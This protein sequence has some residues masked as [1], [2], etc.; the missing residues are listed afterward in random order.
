MCIFQL[1][2]VFQRIHI[3]IQTDV[4]VQ[5]KIL[6]DGTYDFSVNHEV[7]NWSTVGSSCLLAGVKSGWHSFYS[8]FTGYNYLIAILCAV[9]VVG[10]ICFHSDIPWAFPGTTGTGMLYACSISWHYISIY[11]IPWTYFLICI[12]VCFILSLE[13]EVYT[14]LMYLM[15]H[16]IW[17]WIWGNGSC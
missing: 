15:N 7:V 13:F 17:K 11:Y 12:I 2:Y 5:L 16:K 6:K 1:Y 9:A 14:A 4:C 3:R 8:P 10:L